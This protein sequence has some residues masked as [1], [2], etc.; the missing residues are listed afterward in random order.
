M[1]GVFGF[2][3]FVDYLV[4]FVSYTSWLLQYS[5][6]CCDFGGFRVFGLGFGGFVVLFG[7]GVSLLWVGSS[8]GLGFAC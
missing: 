6:L 4:L 8:D 7:S 3:W 5:F 2:I 1:A